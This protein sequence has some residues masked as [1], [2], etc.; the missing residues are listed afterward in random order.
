VSSRNRTRTRSAFTLIEL[1]TVIAIIAI[2]AAIAIGTYF[3]VRVS[4]EEAA[5]ETTL[6]KVH[7]QLDQQWR[8]VLDN[9]RDQW[10]AN[11]DSTLSPRS[12]KWAK[13]MSGGETNRGLAIL[14]KFKLKEEFPQTFW[15]ALVWPVQMNNFGPLDGPGGSVAIPMQ[16][17][18][19]SIILQGLP[20]GTT[21]RDPTMLSA[22]DQYKESAA[23]LYIALTRTRRGNA[24]FNPNEHLG[25]HAVGRIP[26]QVGTNGASKDF[27]I[28]VDTWG[29][30]IGFVRWAFGATG[31]DLNTSP[32][33]ILN[34]LGKPIDPQDPERTLLNPTWRQSPSPNP[35]L[36][37]T[38]E[39]VFKNALRHP[40]PSLGQDPLNLSPVVISSGRDKSFGIDAAH[41]DTYSGQQHMAPLTSNEYDNIY[42]YRVKSGRGNN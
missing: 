32:N 18:Y 9:A 41:D 37:A 33:Q 7:S 11:E 42:S 5:T 28:F 1:L 8:S 35:A 30:P 24:G 39:E 40:L 34:K 36:G 20:Q 19:S 13:L 15:E 4:Q 3:R 25:A 2:L 16:A 29:Q 12:I 10:R 21:P 31:S 26:I 38:Y 14:T 23:L 6:A 17:K 27:D 22:D